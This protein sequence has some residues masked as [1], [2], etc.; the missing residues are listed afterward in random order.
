MEAGT[1]VVRSADFLILEGLDT[2]ILASTHSCHPE[3]VDYSDVLVDFSMEDSDTW[4]FG[5]VDSQFPP[6][7][8]DCSHLTDVLAPWNSRKGERKRFHVENTC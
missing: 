6:E 1:T 8:V 5:R 7:T 4:S 2:R 3:T